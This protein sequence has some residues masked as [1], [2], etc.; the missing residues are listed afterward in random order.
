MKIKFKLDSKKVFS[1]A[2][3]FLLIINIAAFIFVF[4]FIRKY[5]YGS[6]FVDS[7]FLQSQ[8]IKSSGDLDL[9]K[10]NQ[11]VTDIEKR[12]IKNDVGDVKNLFD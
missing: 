1:I 9:N 5:V 6:V 12:Q 4:Q 3:I 11:V 8:Q 7:E 2:Y 10:F